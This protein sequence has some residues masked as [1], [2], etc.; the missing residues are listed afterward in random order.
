METV[1]HPD[2]YAC[3]QSAKRQLSG[4]QMPLPNLLGQRR[5]I[6]CVLAVLCLVSGSLP[7]EGRASAAIS[8]QSNKQSPPPS[9]RL[10][11]SWTPAVAHGQ[12]AEIGAYPQGSSLDVTIALRSHD[13]VGLKAFA[14]AV[15]DPHDPLYHHYLTYAQVNQRFG[16]TPA[17]ISA[18][19][20]WLQGNG[21]SSVSAQAD[22]VSMR[23]PVSLA[24][25]VFG[26]QIDT[27][28][29]H[30]GRVFYGPTQAPA[31]PA[32]L[33]S[34]IAAIIGL[35]NEAQLQPA[36]HPR[37][38]SAIPAQQPHLGSG[39]TGGLHPSGVKKRLRHDRFDRAR[40]RRYRSDYRSL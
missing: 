32:A 31:V 19:A 11:G 13:S 24:T 20:A 33:S 29:L 22:S 18:V 38:R 12:A 35:D 27:W 39:V 28:R 5:F 16:P 7:I 8:A 34:A 23:I 4:S 26:T 1:H 25:T 21:V 9:V 40:R 30:N 10:A 15:S 37:V 14:Q 2:A 6:S 3:K 36:V 17:T